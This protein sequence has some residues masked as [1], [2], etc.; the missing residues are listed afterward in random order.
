MPRTFTSETSFPYPWLHTARGV[1]YKYPNPHATHVRSVD[2][3][4]QSICPRTG[5]LRTERI[6]GVQQNAPRWAAKLLGGGEETYVREVI[7]LDPISN[8]VEMSSTNLSLSQYLLV[9]E[10]ITYTPSATG[11]A[12][13]FRQKATIECRGLQ[14]VLASA[15]RKVEDWS[16]G[17]F[18]DNAAKGRL[19]MMEVLKGLDDRQ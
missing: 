15:A 7:M 13:D 14:G 4:D 5:K 2:V 16:F 19:G 3:L 12:T 8:T 17:R 11:H 10:Y 18:G 1:W 9:K 6:L